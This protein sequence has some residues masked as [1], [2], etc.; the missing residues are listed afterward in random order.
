MTYQYHKSDSEQAAACS[1]E[2]PY[3]IK[4]SIITSLITF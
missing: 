2:G 4:Q 3:R 1:V